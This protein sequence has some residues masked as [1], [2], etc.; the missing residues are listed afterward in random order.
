M[1]GHR[2]SNIPDQE[3]ISDQTIQ[4]AFTSNTSALSNEDS[5]VQLGRPLD[6][7][8][9]VATNPQITS[10]A[11]KYCSPDLDPVKHRRTR[12]GCYTCR[13]R[14]VKVLKLL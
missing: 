9:G 14:R 10:N 8:K 12:S 6:G 2:L 4:Q 7:G 1:S 13:S 3:H 5:P 11:S